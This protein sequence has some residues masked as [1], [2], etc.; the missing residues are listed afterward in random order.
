MGLLSALSVPPP[1][2]MAYD[3]SAASTKKAIR[4]IFYM[5]KMVQN[6]V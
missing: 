2:K 5:K 4:G 6:P 1:G 3:F